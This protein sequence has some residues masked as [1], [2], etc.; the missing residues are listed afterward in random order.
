MLA[1]GLSIE[2]VVHAYSRAT[3]EAEDGTWY[4]A[5]GQSAPVRP[6]TVKYRGEPTELIRVR[7]VH[8]FCRSAAGVVVAARCYVGGFCK[9]A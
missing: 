6:V 2:V 4:R 7:A 9:G 5:L 8:R 1:L 3:G